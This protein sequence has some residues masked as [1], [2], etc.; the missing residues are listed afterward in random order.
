MNIPPS[1][2]IRVPPEKL[3]AFVADAFRRVDV[4]EED[5]GVLADL[6]VCNDLRGVFSHGSRL[7]AYYTEAL[8][9]DLLNPRPKPQVV[10]D[11]PATLTVDGDGGLGYFPALIA[12]RAISR[13]AQDIGVAAAVT[14]SHGHIGAAGIYT[15]IPLAEGLFAYCTSGHQL[16][17]RPDGGILAAA[18]AS[19][20]S[21]AVPAGEEPPLV[22]DFMPRLDYHPNSPNVD[23]AAHM[24]SSAPFRALGLGAVCQTLGGLLTGIPARRERAQRLWE[25]ATQGAFLIAVDLNRFIP[26]DEFRR[27]MDDYV[28]QVHQMRPLPGYDRALLPGHLEWERE[29]EWAVVGVP[30]GKEHQEILQKVARELGVEKPW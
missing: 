25:G 24:S 12:A 2:F 23:L 27:E 18:G 19:P 20:M 4:S 11:G 30:V 5:A 1:E 16:S 8:R 29:R 26:L 14:R 7:V 3:R 28:R 6:L 10:G 13:K 15:R 22:L 21:F 17:L 9:K